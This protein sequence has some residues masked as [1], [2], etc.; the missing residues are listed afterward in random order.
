MLVMVDEMMKINQDIQIS[1]EEYTD[2]IKEIVKSTY[3]YVIWKTE[4][5]E[6]VSS[7]KSNI[8]DLRD[9][10][11][12]Q[13]EI[14]KRNQVVDYFDERVKA[15]VYY[16]LKNLESYRQIGWQKLKYEGVSKDEQV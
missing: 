6:L 1:N 8:E 4:F 10:L 15:T 9:I 12:S 7:I 16:T 13:D 3:E 2:E 5:K 14:I 11:L